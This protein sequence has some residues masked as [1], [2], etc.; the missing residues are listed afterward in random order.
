MTADTTTQPDATPATWHLAKVDSQRWMIVGGT[1]ERSREMWAPMPRCLYHPHLCRMVAIDAQ[2]AP[3]K[4]AQ[5]ALD[6]YRRG[7][8]PPCYRYTADGELEPCDGSDVDEDLLPPAD[9][10]VR[11]QARQAGVWS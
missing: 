3:R 5:E 6:A 9:R 2:T 11:R 4:I 8:R 10:I 7:E 1:D